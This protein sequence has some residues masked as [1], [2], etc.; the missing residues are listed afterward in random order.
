MAVHL[1]RESTGQYPPAQWSRKDKG[2]ACT[3]FYHQSS[4]DSGANTDA[5]LS[6]VKLIWEIQEAGTRDFHIFPELALIHQL[7]S[8]TGWLGVNFS[9]AVTF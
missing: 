7:L 2:K 6:Q 5:S 8:T 4:N 9:L 1:T 3:F